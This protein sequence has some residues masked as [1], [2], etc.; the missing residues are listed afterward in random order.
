MYVTIYPNFKCQLKMCYCVVVFY[1][2]VMRGERVSRYVYIS[3]ILGLKE[4]SVS[5]H[6]RSLVLT[7]VTK[8]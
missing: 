3:V 5:H 7:T 6:V 2:E 4:L 8:M 1:S